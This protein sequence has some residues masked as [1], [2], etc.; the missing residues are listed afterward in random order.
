[1]MLYLEMNNCALFKKILE[2]LSTILT[3]ISFEFKNNK[4][5]LSTTDDTQTILIT[6]KLSN[7]EK[8]EHDN[9][10]V[11][12]ISLTNILK[13]L[14]YIEK[15]ELL[16]MKIDNDTLVINQH[17]KSTYKLKLI[18]VEHKHFDT[19][20]IEFDL[21]IVISQDEFLNLCQELA[22]IGD[23]VEISCSNDRIKF[24][25]KGNCI[26]YEKYLTNKDIYIKY[27]N[28]PSEFSSTYEIKNICLFSKC[29][30]FCENIEMYIKKNGPLGIKYILNNTDRISI[31]ISRMNDE[32]QKFNEND[33]SDDDEVR[34][35]I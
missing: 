20:K 21:V 10:L 34:F 30:P 13:S 7:F 11:M 28:Q 16:K 5:Y 6:A 31:F 22:Q 18:D 23:R 3:D 8:I 17:E 2:I 26:D 35:K 27:Y 24:I 25:C 29:V 19:S 32:I 4:L 1:M 15:K 12:G 14:K 33:Y 9:N